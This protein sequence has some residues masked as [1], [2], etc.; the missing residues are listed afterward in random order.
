[1]SIAEGVADRHY[2]GH[3]ETGIISSAQQDSI[4]NATAMYH[5]IRVKR[6][7]SIITRNNY[8][9]PTPMYYVTSTFPNASEISL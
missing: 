5:I 9:Q 7:K 3:G 1:M 4:E 6:Q 8:F 2:F